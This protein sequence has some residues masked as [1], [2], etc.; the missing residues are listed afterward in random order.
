MTPE[1]KRRLQ[2]IQR[3]VANSIRSKPEFSTKEAV[4]D[5]AVEHYYQHLKKLKFLWPQHDHKD[6]TGRKAIHTS[7][8]ARPST[9]GKRFLI[10]P[11]KDQRPPANKE[12]DLTLCSIRISTTN[13]LSPNEDHPWPLK[14]C[15]NI[16]VFS[17]PTAAPRVTTME[18]IPFRSSKWIS[19]TVPHHVYERLI[20]L[21][22]QEGRSI[23]NLAAFQLEYAMEQMKMQDHPQRSRFDSS[24]D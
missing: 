21:S 2:E 4:L 14:V 8:L 6:R 1:N 23:S 16:R 13:K 10:H 3:R 17:K 11:N 20:N 24:Q 9:H 15:F 19:I 18:T 7:L 22:N 5:A 12:S